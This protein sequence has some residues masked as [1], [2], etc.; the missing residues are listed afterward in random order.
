VLDRVNRGLLGG[1]RNW[2]VGLAEGQID[3][4]FDIPRFFENAADD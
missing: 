4:V 3:G 2:E 1:I